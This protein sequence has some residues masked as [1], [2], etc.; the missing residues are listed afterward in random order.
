MD[1]RARVMSAGLVKLIIDPDGKLR[2]LTIAAGL[3]AWQKLL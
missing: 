3:P 2:L 1:A